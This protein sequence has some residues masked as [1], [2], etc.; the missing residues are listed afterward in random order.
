LP[1]TSIGDLIIAVTIM[2]HEH[3]HVFGAN[4][5]QDPP[6]SVPRTRCNGYDNACTTNADCSTPDVCESHHR[7]RFTQNQVCSTNSDCVPPRCNHNYKAA[8]YLM[9]GEVRLNVWPFPG[10]PFGPQCSINQVTTKINS[11]SVSCLGI[12][13][14]GDVNRNTVVT[15][16]DALAALHEANCTSNCAYDGLAD[17]YPAPPTGTPNGTVTEEDADLIL[18]AAVGSVALMTCG[19]FP[20][21]TIP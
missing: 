10:I 15:S 8:G 7:C 21:P 12:V 9:W 20:P 18:Q 6:C 14:C 11:S 3:G 19:N 13:H 4:H 2:A 1:G 16:S 17:V 5:I